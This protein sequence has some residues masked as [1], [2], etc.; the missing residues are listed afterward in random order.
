M[1]YFFEDQI[2]PPMLRNTNRINNADIKKKII[3][4][5]K[6]FYESKELIILSSIF[7]ARVESYSVNHM[8]LTAGNSFAA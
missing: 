4:I 6:T 1:P 3:Y 8:I 7:L 5:Q 2:I